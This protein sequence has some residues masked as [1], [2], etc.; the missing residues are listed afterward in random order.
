[1]DIVS[2][3]STRLLALLSLLQARPHWP[4]ATLAERLEVSARTVRRDVDR[5]R[6]LGY[7]VHATHGPGAAYRLG[8][9]AQ[10]P[11]LLLDDEQ[12]VAVA[13]A[14]QAAPP[15]VAG[16]DQA[17]AQA[18]TVVRQVMPARLRARVD[19]VEVTSVARPGPVV[20]P[21]VLLALGAAVRAQEVLRADL[22]GGG[23]RRV[24][25]H[26]LITWGGRWYLLAFD[27]DR[28]DWRTFRVDR[29][30]PRTPTGPRFTP[31]EVPGG[32]VAAWVQARLGRY[33]RPEP[34]P[35][36]GTVLLHVDAAVIAGRV[37]GSVVED[38][39]QGHCRV[40]LGAWSW[41]ALAATAALFDAVIEH[42]EPAELR[43]A[44]G[45]LAARARIAAH[46]HPPTGAP[47]PPDVARRRTRD[48]PPPD[49][50]ITQ[51]D[52]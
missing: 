5:L 33:D 40:V 25:P 15:S 8:A 39:G 35:V 27:L 42:A 12:A 14:L 21:A 41:A 3:T 43:E 36:S 26:H 23:L 9:G 7:P 10:L 24:E 4:A 48:D 11:P 1:M 51:R 52:N 32:D 16:L 29:L 46:A 18:L 6:T 47:A 22:Q 28:S 45:V 44:F 2:A 17:A 19:A 38:W 13:L 50:Q 31:R 20:E 49:Q 34:W 37:R 30:T